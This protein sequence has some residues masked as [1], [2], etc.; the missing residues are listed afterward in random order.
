M[1]LLQMSFSGAILTVAII[2]VRAV[3]IHKLPKRTFLALWGI[4]LLRLLIPFSIPSVWSAYSLINCAE[5][6]METISDMPISD[7]IPTAPARQIP[8]DGNTVQTL[9]E[10]N[11]VQTQILQGGMQVS[12]WTV[13]WCVGTML[14]I[15][16]FIISYLHWR[17][18]FKTSLPV[19]DPFITQWLREHRLKRPISVRQSGSTTTPLTYGVFRPVIL[20]PQKTD[21]GN[22]QQ[23]QYI[24]LHEYV[25]ICRYDIVTKW[26][27]AIAL[28]IHWFNPM[29]WVMYILFNRDLEL[30]CDECVIQK[31]G[32]NVKSAYART[33]ISMEEK[34]GGLMP[35]GNN[36]SKNAIEERIIAIMRIKKT[37]FAA[38]IIATALVASVT[39]AFATSATA[40]NKQNT[41]VPVTDFSEE[42]Y[43]KLLA[44]RFDGYETMSVSEYQKKVWELT[45]TAAYRN[46]LER[47]SQSEKLY[48][49]KDSNETASFL[50]YVLEPLTA[51][52]WQSREFGGAVAAAYPQASDNA[53]LEY[54]ITLEISDADTLTV[55]EYDAA[56]QNAVRDLDDLMKNM[57]T[58]ELRDEAFMHEI[59]H[60]EIAAITGM[61]GANGL[62]LAIQY[63]YVPLGELPV[64]D[65]E[66]WQ[67][68]RQKEWDRVLSLYA[69]F[70][71][72]WQYDFATD[73][74]KMYFQGKEVRGIVDERE[75]LWITEHSGSGKDI[76]DKNAV[77]I[78]AVYE[79]DELTGLREATEQEQEE[80]SDM[81]Q[82][83]TDE[84]K[85][86]QETREYP[87][88]TEE[89][90]RSLLALKTPDYSNRSVA[91]FN[92]DLLEWANE[93][94]E[95]MERINIDTGWNDF[96]VSLDS[97]E[98][99]FVKWTVYLSGTENAKY[100]QSTY[101]GSAEEEPIYNQSLPEK[102]VV[103]N[104]R[105]AWC[106]LWYQFSYA[107][108][109][110]E[111][112]TV[113]ERDYF[114][115]N[116]VGD[117]EKFWNE[118]GTEEML[119]MTE[120]DVVKELQRIAEKYSN[121]QIIFT[122][123]EEHVQFETMDERGID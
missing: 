57:T 81:R 18:K 7:L 21:W 47:F 115:E 44:L 64:D 3:F 69:P 52:R 65:M 95:R 116:M 25:H 104:G 27:C 120:G 119:K 55:G 29:V 102:T 83:T 74:Y 22:K 41:E 33:L 100:V 78:Y 13:I 71:L 76:Y 101:M 77:E 85:E 38:I 89:D 68:E 86:A 73:D 2:A 9:P 98:L 107:I 108:A 51:E 1:N 4:V 12:V 105:A 94:Y 30:A 103:E 118:T 53:S 114:V 45:D 17:F 62:K 109:D 72:T 16:F 8:S 19:S 112:I 59:I 56:R 61:Y 122:I 70:G 93:N 37:S 23:L 11:G 63:V 24:L 79:N 39:T 60:E 91:D 26:I 84:W 15:A 88:G 31:S 99:S 58:S 106:G 66:E 54:I 35:I 14:C 87:H 10:D 20:M 34:K 123:D 96:Q 5:P 36:F 110:K 117:I 90:Y 42:E 40:D 48:A 92:M 113:G 6:V 111:A 82:R 121:D 50:F 67:K 80:W 43:E 49:M 28:C 97:E 75:G 32:E 46:L